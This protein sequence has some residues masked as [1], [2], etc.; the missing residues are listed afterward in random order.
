[1]KTAILIRPI[2]PGS[3]ADG[4]RHKRKVEASTVVEATQGAILRHHDA[5]TSLAADIPPTMSAV[6]PLG[7]AGHLNKAHRH[8]LPCRS[9]S[10]IPCP[11]SPVPI[12]NPRAQ[13]GTVLD[14]GGPTPWVLPQPA[15]PV[16]DL[17]LAGVAERNRLRCSFGGQGED[18]DEHG[19]KRHH[20]PSSH[21]SPTLCGH[22][23][24]DATF[25]AADA[26]RLLPISALLTG[27]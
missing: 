16:L 26:S 15:A 3:A 21:H 27:T 23:I 12:K 9:G 18:H 6:G 10:E 20:K 24:H 14:L 2:A 5:P 22:H 4:I 7:H 19:T 8:A 1:M 25:L 11:R 17:H 13:L